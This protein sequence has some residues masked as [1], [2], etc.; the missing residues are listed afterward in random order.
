M[1]RNNSK[2]VHKNCCAVVR[3]PDNPLKY[4]LA[5]ICFQADFFDKKSPD[6]LWNLGLSD[7]HLLRS[8]KVARTR[9]TLLRSVI[10]TL[11]VW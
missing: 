7:L 10:R 2:S 11:S 3:I 1:G 4:P 9:V 5:S 8:E 6:S